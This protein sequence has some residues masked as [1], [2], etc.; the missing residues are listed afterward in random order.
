MSQKRD[1]RIRRIARDRYE[2][3]LY[4]WQMNKPSKWRFFKYRKWKK[5]KPVYEYAEKQIKKIAKKKV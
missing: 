2:Y 1:K 5:S 3:Q 4:Y